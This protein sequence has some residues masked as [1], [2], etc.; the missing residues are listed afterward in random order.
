MI[1][2][3]DLKKLNSRYEAAF[4]Q[5]MKT[6]LDKG[7]YVLGDEVGE[8]ENQFASYCGTKYC[9]GV[10]NGLDALV[11]IF[12]AYIAL[13]KLQKGDEIIVPANTFIASVLAILQADLVPVLVE[14]NEVT[15]NIEP[16]LISEKITP[17]TKGILAVHLYGQ[18]AD[19]ELLNAIA[20]ENDLLVIEDAAQAHG[21]ILN[22]ERAGNLA[23]AAAFSFYPGKNFGALGDGGAITTNDNELAEVLFSLRNYGSK[24]KYENDYIGVNSRLDEIQAAF[25]NVKLPHLDADNEKRR[26]IAKRYMTE[27][28]NEKISLP[29]WDLSKNHVFHLFVIRTKERALLQQYLFDNG[30]Q[31][32]IHYPIPPHKQK[33]LKDWN[34]LS[35]PVTEKIYEEVLSLP[36]S[37]VITMGEVDF[38]ITILN[39]F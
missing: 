15:Y 17:K 10:G 16:N 23:N 8:F 12:K 33:A 27:V 37:P 31:T 24:V 13:G 22:K 30:I 21:A 36:I 2:F 1:P 25:L 11:L 38:I 18:L 9:V 26:A 14:P 4:Q 29:V 7:W 32:V 19:M 35:L 28:K 5:K 6:F 20:K 34:Q 39:S 3:L